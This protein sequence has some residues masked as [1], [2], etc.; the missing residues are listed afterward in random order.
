MAEIHSTAVVDPGAELASDV[1]VEAFAVVGPCVELGPGVIVGPHAVVSGRTRVGAGTLIS[2]H[3]CLGCAP[4]HRDHAGESTR[5]EIGCENEIREHVTISLGTVRGGGCTV[6][7]DRN[8]LMNASHVGH[9]CRI[10]SNCEIASF[11]GLAGHVVVEDFA[12]LGAYTGIHQHCRVGENV[13]AASGAKL[14]LDAPPFT[15]VAGDRAR[16]VGL[17]DIGL[18]R[19]GVS[20]DR[21]LALKR[22]FRTIFRSGLRLEEATRQLTPDFAGHPEIEHLLGFLQESERGFCR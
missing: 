2:S 13:M 6:I 19:R 20:G 5:L 3:A 4:Q 10:G 22:A 14:S 8:L 1:R 16:L 7:G 21:Q 12:V 11:S 15:L 17:N 9:D 18:R